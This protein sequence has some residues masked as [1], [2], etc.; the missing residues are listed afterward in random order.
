MHTMFEV[1]LSLCWIF[2]AFIYTMY[3][4]NFFLSDILYID[5]HT[6]YEVFPPL[7]DILFLESRCMRVF[8]SSVRYFMPWYIQCMRFIFSSQI[9]YTLVIDTHTIYEVYFFLSLIFYALSQDEWEF[10][11]PLLDVLCIETFNVWGSFFS[12]QIF[13]TLIHTQS[14]RFIFFSLWYFMHW[15]KMHEG[16]LFLC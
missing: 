1:Y 6:I 16:F 3:E 14:M 9:F 12:S 13:Y 2:Y 11:I 15:V 7:F 10:S 5:T 4:V 8:F